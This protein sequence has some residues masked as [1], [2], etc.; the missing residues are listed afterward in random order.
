MK[1]KINFSFI[2]LDIFF[3][4]FNSLIFY[5]ESRTVLTYS[6]LRKNYLMNIN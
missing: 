5:T 3:T 6:D 4:H 2:R 1:P